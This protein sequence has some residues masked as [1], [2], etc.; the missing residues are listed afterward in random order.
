MIL[1]C[2]FNLIFL[3]CV[4]RTSFSYHKNAKKK[5]QTFLGQPFTSRGKMI[6]HFYR[7]GEGGGVGGREGTLP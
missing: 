6:F 4:Y 2:Y 5:F 3:M 1:I 7:G